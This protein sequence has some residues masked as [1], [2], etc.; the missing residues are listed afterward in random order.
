LGVDPEALVLSE[1][2][3]AKIVYR[4]GGPVS[5][6]ELEQLCIKVGWPK[7]PADKVAGALENS[8]LVRSSLACP[9]NMLLHSR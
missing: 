3:G 5:V 9:C 4:P 8:F 7:R 2:D 1:A 6:A